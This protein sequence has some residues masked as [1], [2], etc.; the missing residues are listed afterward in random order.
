MA[1]HKDFEKMPDGSVLLGILFLIR[2]LTLGG[3]NQASKRGR[4]Y[5][6]STRT[7]LSCLV[8]MLWTKRGS[9][10][11]LYWFLTQDLEYN[12][13]ILKA[14][15]LKKVP[16]RRTFDRRFATLP[17]EKI[18]SD[19]GR[20]FIAY[21]FIDAVVV[22]IDST[23]MNA[24]RYLVHHKKDKK[25]GKKPRPG[26]DTEAEWTRKHGN[27]TYGYKCHQVTSTG[28][29]PV[30]LAATTTPANAAD[31]KVAMNMLSDLPL[32]VIQVILGDRA[33][34]DSKLFLKVKELTSKE[35]GGKGGRLLTWTRTVAGGIRRGNKKSGPLTRAEAARQ[36]MAESDEWYLN[37]GGAEVYAQRSTTVE[38][39]QGRLKSTF[40]LDSVPVRGKKAVNQRVLGCIFTY[41]L[42]I[43]YG[44]ATEQDNP[45]QVKYLVGS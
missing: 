35:N 14:C 32:Q 21:K 10:R 2:I 44:F 36:A 12:R 13:K 6:F 19:M 23:I 34:H 26:I 9:V 7:I 33:Y 8:V 43:F 15:G 38:P 42:A 5:V 30:P 11:S 18:I 37:G 4:P 24:W 41:Q 27:Y 31:N 3:E 28:R 29:A 20:H 39:E 40:G 22:A 17:L 45:L 16:D 25:A 1:R